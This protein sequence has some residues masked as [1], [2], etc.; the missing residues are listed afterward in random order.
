MNRSWH[1]GDRLP[2]LLLTLCF[3]H[4]AF[5][6]GRDVEGAGRDDVRHITD[7]GAVGDGAADDT[8][9]LQAAIDDLPADGGVVRVA[10]GTYQLGTVRLRTGT[11]LVGA[12]RASV[13]RALPDTPAILMF[14]EGEQRG[15]ALSDL[16]LDGAHADDRTEPGIGLFL[17]APARVVDLTVQRVWFRNHA[18]DAILVG[19]APGEGHANLLFRDVDIRATGLTHGCGFNIFLDINSVGVVVIA[20]D[21]AH[22]H[23]GTVTGNVIRGCRMWGLAVSGGRHV[24]ITGNTICDNGRG[25]GRDDA[26]RILNPD[27]TPLDPEESGVGLLLGS[28]RAIVVTGNRIGNSLPNDT[29]AVGVREAGDCDAN[30]IFGNDLTE[31]TLSALMTAGP[32]TRAW[33]NLGVD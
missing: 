2:C 12:G 20:E 17:R 8:A 16:V 7:F 22:C 4:A 14:Q 24:T 30:L 10:P 32:G 15:I 6:P 33:G 28:A 23:N 26:G 29:Q 1:T 9:A 18:A 11:R 25:W 19:G 5:L 21:T 27:G 13:L 31:N 3:V